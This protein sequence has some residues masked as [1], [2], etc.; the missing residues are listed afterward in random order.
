VYAPVQSRVCRFL[1]DNE[2]DFPKS[3]TEVDVTYPEDL[4]D[5]EAEHTF[6]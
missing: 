3:I 1:T 6:V 5:V 2:A 4:P